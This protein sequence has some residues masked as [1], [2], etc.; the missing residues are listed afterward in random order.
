MPYVEAKQRTRLLNN[1]PGAPETPGELNFM[2]SYICREYM[3]KKQRRYSTFNDIIG[4][5]DAAKLEFYRRV[6]GPY[7]NK[8]IK[9]NGDIYDPSE[10]E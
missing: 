6:V 1:F 2:L 5:L 3:R 10:V 9:R 7:E 8:A 4:A